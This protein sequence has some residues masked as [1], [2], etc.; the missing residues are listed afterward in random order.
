MVCFG[1]KYEV[2]LLE[3]AMDFLRKLEGKLQAKAFRSIDLLGYFGPQLLMPHSRKLTGYDLW[4]L[5]VQQ[6]GSICRVFYFHSKD[7]LYVVTSG[8]VK[9]SDK[10]NPGEIRK[11]L[12]LKAEYLGGIAE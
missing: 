6:A 1:M 12:R 8:Y 11:A 4:E 7:R 10:T 2:V 9:K 5:R 3:P